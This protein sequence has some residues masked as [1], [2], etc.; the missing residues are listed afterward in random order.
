MM[1]LSQSHGRS[2]TETATRT[3]WRQIQNLQGLTRDG[4]LEQLSLL[5]ARG[6]AWEPCKGLG[7]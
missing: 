5:R 4:Q 3:G 1:G 7:R 2:L 6:Y